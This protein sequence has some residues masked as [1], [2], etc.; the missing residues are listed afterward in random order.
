[1]A[2]GK[3]QMGAVL[4]GDDAAHR[5]DRTVA[6]AA[7][8]RFS[9]SPF[10]IGHVLLHPY[11]GNR[12]HCSVTKSRTRASTDASAGASSTSAIQPLSAMVSA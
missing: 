4:T 8:P 5:V 3:W 9:H 1:M 11:T 2:N 12:P 10:A 6:I 7:S